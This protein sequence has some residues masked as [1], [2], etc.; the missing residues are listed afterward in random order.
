M[1]RA[2]ASLAGHDGSQALPI[3]WAGGCGIGWARRRTG[4]RL[5]TAVGFGAATRPF[6]RRPPSPPAGSTSRG[7]SDGVVVPAQAVWRAGWW[8][9]C[10][11]VGGGAPFTGV[12]GDAGG[13]RGGCRRRSGSDLTRVVGGAPP[14]PPRPREPDS[15]SG[16]EA[17]RLPSPRE[18]AGERWAG[19]VVIAAAAAAWRARGVCVSGLV[20]ARLRE[21]LR[22]AGGNVFSSTYRMRRAFAGAAGWGWDAA[23]GAGADRR[24]GG[25]RVVVPRRLL[26]ARGWTLP[27][28]RRPR[29]NNVSGNGTWSGCYHH[30]SWP[31][32]GRGGGAA[33]ALARG[34]MA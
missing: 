23:I 3:K 26:G 10:Q 1:G 14:S 4:G 8:R 29:S 6:Q 7:W 20:G 31:T 2:G 19:G 34:V 9:V 30:G 18:L 24:R 17:R 33:I 28:P 13:W 15:V 11:R 22:G 16:N 12:S 32:R 21:R 25:G 5:F 27:S